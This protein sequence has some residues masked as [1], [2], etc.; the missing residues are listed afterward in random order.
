MP[1][2]AVY[3]LSL[4]ALG[5]G[6]RGIDA[7]RG[8]IALDFGGDACDGYTLNYRQVTV[9]NGGETGSRT[10]DVAAPRPSRAGDGKSMRFKTNSTTG[11]GGSERRRRRCAAEATTVPSMFGSNSPKREVLNV[12][13]RADLSHRAHEAPHRGRARRGR[14]PSP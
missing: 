12:A 6:S 10:L 3:D 4:V 7:A 1:H 9:L 5:R 11:G 14:R 2:R 13:R 8:R